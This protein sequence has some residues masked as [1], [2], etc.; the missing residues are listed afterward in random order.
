MTSGNQFRSL[1]FLLAVFLISCGNTSS[2]G[3]NEFLFPIP[4]PPEGYRSCGA[5][6]SRNLSGCDFNYNGVV[7]DNIN[8]QGFNLKGAYL[9]YKEMRNANLKDANLE[10]VVLTFAELQ[11][12]NLSGANLKKA[13]LSGADLTGANLRG[14]NLENA[15]LKG[16][17]ISRAILS[18]AILKGTMMPSGYR[19]NCDLSS[20]H[21][22]FC[23]L[24]DAKLVSLKLRGKDLTGANLVGVDLTGADLS[25][26]TLRYA[27]LARANLSKTNLTNADMMDA[28]LEDANLENANLEYSNLIGTNLS[29]ANMTGVRLGG[30]SRYLPPITPTRPQSNYSPDY[31]EGDDPEPPRPGIGNDSE[32]DYGYDDGPCIG[33]CNDMDGDGR[34]SDDIDRDGDGLYE[35]P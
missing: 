12:A 24:S 34:T 15:N 4:K 11:D 14:A 22:K 33:D 9:P 31:L 17:D 19:I 20:K 30:S 10:R 35:S 26:A 23:D 3:G 28:S 27:R 32:N 5:F 16:A 18:D 13:D 25:G 8:L 21:L 7:F 2:S 1:F 29:G 6:S